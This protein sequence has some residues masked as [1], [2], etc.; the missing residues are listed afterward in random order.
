MIALV[1]LCCR[2]TVM[3][4]L[5]NTDPQ[6][7]AERQSESQCLKHCIFIEQWFAKDTGGQR[8]PE[9]LLRMRK[10]T[11]LKSIPDEE[12]LEWKVNLGCR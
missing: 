5:W 11:L 10:P 2:D 3:V 6:C 7:T 4:L 12:S 1:H 8:H 9:C